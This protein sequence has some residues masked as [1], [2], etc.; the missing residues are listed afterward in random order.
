LF[1]YCLPLVIEVH[2][3]DV[4]SA[5]SISALRDEVYLLAVW[6]PD[7]AQVVGCM[8]GELGEVGAVGPACIDVGVPILERAGLYLATASH[9]E[10]LAVGRDDRRCE[11]AVGVADD[12][13]FHT[14]LVVHPPY[15]A[16]A[17]G[18]E[19]GAIVG[20]L[21]RDGIGVEADGISGQ[22]IVGHAIAPDAEAVPL[23]A[24]EED[25][26]HV[27][28]ID[29]RIVL[30]AAG[31]LPADIAV[32]GVG[33]EQLALFSSHLR[34]ADVLAVGREGEVLHAL[35]VGA[36]HAAALLAE[37]GNE[38]VGGIISG[39]QIGQGGSVGRDAQD[40]VGEPA[41]AIGAALHDGEAYIVACC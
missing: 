40:A 25:L 7:G 6:A 18:T 31:N 21:L 14:C 22:E 27:V 20:T 9:E 38:D 19:S 29:G 32:L 35:S 4:G 3:P 17:H 34:E 26:L 28:G 23:L 33:L 10:P 41:H 15:L 24:S 16:V 1:P 39:G 13:F 5:F 12:A 37:V 8:V 11:G 2:A 30:C 36:L